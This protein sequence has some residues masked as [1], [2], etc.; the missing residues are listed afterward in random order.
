[1]NMNGLGM[2]ILVDPLYAV[3]IG[4]LAIIG[5]ISLYLQGKSNTSSAK[6]YIY[7]KYYLKIW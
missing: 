2:I 3:N 7:P 5:K 6:P 1:M 4:I